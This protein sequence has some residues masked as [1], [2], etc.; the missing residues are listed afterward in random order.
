M[1]RELPKPVKRALRDL[2]GQ[3]HERALR[4]ALGELRRDFDLWTAGE[5]D[6]FELAHRIHT[7]HQGPDRQIHV[8]YTHGSDLQFLVAQSLHEG[9]LDAADIPAEV[10]PHLQTVLALF[11]EF[12][13]KENQ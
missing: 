6:A 2:A 11:G 7:F 13:E 4:A 10:M 5:I 3:A 12:E 9:L 1:N 8:R